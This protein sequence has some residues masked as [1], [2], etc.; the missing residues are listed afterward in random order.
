MDPPNRTQRQRCW[1]ARDAYYKCLD[2]LKVNTPG[3]E[4]GKCA[5]EV[6]AFSKAC[7]ASWVEHFNRKRVFDIKQAAALRGG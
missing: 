6:A 3:E 5:E 1:E 7:A 4:G 2:S